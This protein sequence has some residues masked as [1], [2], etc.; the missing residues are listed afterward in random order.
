MLAI[1]YKIEGKHVWTNGKSDTQHRPWDGCSMEVVRSHWDEF[2]TFYY[3][4]KCHTHS[5]TVHGQFY[6][7]EELKARFDMS[8]ID[9]HWW[10]IFLY[11]PRLTAIMHTKRTIIDQ[12]GSALTIVEAAE[13]ATKYLATLDR[14]W[15]VLDVE[16][17]HNLGRYYDTSTTSFT[18]YAYL[19]D[20]AR[21]DT[22]MSLIW[23]LR[24]KSK[25]L[26]RIEITETFPRDY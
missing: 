6:S 24:D 9:Q 16:S 15:P 17:N 8:C 19:A 7:I 22:Q 1:D 14:L 25:F 18:S 20:V 26:T 11:R 4:C 21:L 10:W 2:T 3:S 5:A 12:T 13:H 23:S